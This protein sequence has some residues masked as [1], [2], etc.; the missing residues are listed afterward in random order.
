MIINPKPQKNP[1]YSSNFYKRSYY[2]AYMY[3]ASAV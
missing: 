3:M 1:I 2:L